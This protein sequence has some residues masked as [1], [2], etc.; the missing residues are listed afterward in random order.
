MLAPCR[1][2]QHHHHQITHQA[3]ASAPSALGP[4]E[5]AKTM[6]VGTLVIGQV[7]GAATVHAGQKKFAWITRVSSKRGTQEGSQSQTTFS[8]S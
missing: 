2:Y 4:T 3:M 8:N 7:A 5:T 6:A 1:N